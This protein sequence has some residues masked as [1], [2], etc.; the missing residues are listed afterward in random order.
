M[1]SPFDLSFIDLMPEDSELKSLDGDSKADSTWLSTAPWLVLA[2][3][4][5]LDD[6]KEAVAQLRAEGIRV[7]VI[8]LMRVSLDAVTET[9]D[10]L[11]G[12]RSGVRHAVV[13]G[14]ELAGL[15]AQALPTSMVI[16]VGSPSQIPERVRDLPRCC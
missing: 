13:V 9:T 15:A 8:Y 6:V 3:L 4:L 16:E 1:H 12:G 10:K 11:P 5:E 14:S 2:T 7:N